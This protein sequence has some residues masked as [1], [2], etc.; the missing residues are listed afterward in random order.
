MK[1][2]CIGGGP[3]GLY[4]GV[5]LK[6]A[7]PRHEV[8]IFERNR[9]DD[10]FGFGVVFSDATLG[11][12]ADADPVTHA[13]ITSRFARWDDIETHVRGH[14]FTS[15]G[16]G[17]CGIERKELLVI[18]QDRARELGV[19][20]RFE[21]PVTS[22]DDVKDADLVVACDGVGSWVRDQLA[23]QFEPDVDVRPNKFV[24][25]GTT[26]PFTAFTF[27]FKETAHGLFRVHAYRYSDTG[28]TFIVECTPATWKAAGLDGAD[29]D[30]T[31]AVLEDIFAAELCGHRLIKNRSIWRSFPTVRNKRWRAGNVVL[32]GDAAHTAHFSIG[33]GT[34]L[35]MEDAIALRDAIVAEHDVGTALATYEMRRRPEVEALQAA[36]Q[37]SLEWFEGT[38]R[39]LELPPA[40]FGYSLM[41]R[42]LRVSHASMLRRDPALARA[43]ERVLAERADLE[44][45]ADEAAPPPMFTAVE[46]AG[47]RLTNR[48]A[49]APWP[50]GAADGG[51]VG[52][53]HLV[54]L[55]ARAS[56]GAGL[57]LT[58]VV[59]AS[60]AGTVPAIGTDEQAVAW[61]RVV[62]FVH[63][64]SPAKIGVVIT[65]G[66]GAGAGTG[67]GVGAELAEA[68]RRAAF[69]GF[70]LLV[71]D[72]AAASPG[73]LD[74]SL[75]AVRAAWPS[76]RPLGVRVRRGADA[77]S[78]VAQAG[79]W[80]A[81]GAN[82]IVVA[83]GATRAS[84]ARLDAAP[85]ADRLRN[86]L[87]LAVI[88]E[89]A[90]ATP[91]DVDAVIAAGRCDV[92]A[93]GRA[94]VSD[95]GF[96]ERAAEAAGW[97]RGESAAAS[98]AVSNDG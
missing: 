53:G 38:E 80:R 59:A 45:D 16:H 6:L 75:A 77:A 28:S 9:P 25:L 41:T 86:E 61:R 88:L 26:V 3:A 24:W 43:V 23:A 50:A 30:R 48:I 76:E 14:V 21:Q 57:V 55:G 81:L 69:A 60:G 73:V 13:A 10:T 89:D 90:A 79:A 97:R 32:M 47:L 84:G 20:V 51:V 68:A 5:L 18:L 56:G 94:L 15:T 1:T 35:A 34:K 12:L 87:D 67:A 63:E 62:E 44:L 92:V 46:L 72:A 98:P 39:Y 31:I 64:K 71:L 8:T 70:D 29:E 82:V 33:S 96:V 11:N 58:E 4:L 83:P 95:P 27:I 7:Q 49:L 74:G 85:L 36:A 91:A 66:A 19:D 22:L 78:M 42:S 37:A 2:V 17:F 54:F 40:Q 65:A 52:D 93:L